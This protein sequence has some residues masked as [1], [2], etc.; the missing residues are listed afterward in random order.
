MRAENLD[1][2]R[3]CDSIERSGEI[4]TMS[5]YSNALKSKCRDMN[6]YDLKKLLDYIFQRR[7]AKAFNA[8]KPIMVDRNKR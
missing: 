2:K 6:D 8:V 3:I 5:G 7:N 4:T 1:V